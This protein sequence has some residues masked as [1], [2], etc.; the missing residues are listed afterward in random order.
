MKIFD[1]DITTAAKCR[2]ENNFISKVVEMSIADMEPGTAYEIGYGSDGTCRDKLERAM[3]GRLGYGPAGVFQIGAAIAANSGP[4]VAGI[5]FIRK[6]DKG[7]SSH[8]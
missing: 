6:K 3:A 7:E 2:G 8:I 4:K 5:S 1:R